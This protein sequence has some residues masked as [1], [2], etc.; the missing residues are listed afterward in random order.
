M[1]EDRM[2]A[3]ALIAHVVLEEMI[4]ATTDAQARVHLQ[5]ALE[6]LERV[7]KSGLM[8]PISPEAMAWAEGEA[9]RLGL[10]E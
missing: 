2:R 6:S 4:L 3:G 5:D 9:R 1:S 7:Q 10:I 8:R